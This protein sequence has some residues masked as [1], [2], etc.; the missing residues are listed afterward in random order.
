MI[1]EKF[2]S[3][4]FEALGHDSL[5]A[6]RLA[7]ELQ[8]AIAEELL[9][10]LRALAEK[11]AGSLRQLGHHVQESEFV[12]D[13]DGAAYVGF[14]DS[15]RGSEPGYHR[16]RFDLDLTV[17]AGYPRYKPAPPRPRLP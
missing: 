3:E 10:D 14:V 1:D 6:N 2:S 8:G 9:A 5:E 17:S 13:A 4:H 12:V 15:S 16:L 11:I 7:T